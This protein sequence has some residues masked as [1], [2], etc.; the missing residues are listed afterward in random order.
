M[1]PRLRQSSALTAWLPSSQTCYRSSN[2]GLADSK[3][4]FR[5]FLKF[6]NFT[7]RAGRTSTTMKDLARAHKLASTARASLLAKDSVLQQLLRSSLCMP[8]LTLTILVC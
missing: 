1:L 3:P 8:S 2:V 4:V 5:V 7:A 6:L